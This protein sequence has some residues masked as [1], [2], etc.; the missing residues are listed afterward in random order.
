M[1]EELWPN[2]KHKAIGDQADLLELL[3]CA[4]SVQDHKKDTW[5]G[6]GADL[7]GIWLRGVLLQLGQL[8][9]MSDIIAADCVTSPEKI[10]KR[11]THFYLSA[12]EKLL[13]AKTQC[14]V[15]TEHLGKETK[16]RTVEKSGR[17]KRREVP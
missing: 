10:S 17:R 1:G 9:S 6:K 4:A 14:F 12:V 3:A 15:L 2:A 8:L 16:E 7:L 5:P 13:C 11:P